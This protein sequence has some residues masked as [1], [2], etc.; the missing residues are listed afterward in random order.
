M[1]QEPVDACPWKI[2]PGEI[3]D[4]KKKYV[5]ECLKCQLVTHEEDLR[6]LVDY[7]SGSMHNWAGGYGGKLLAPE[8][9][10]VRRLTEI[11]T[12]Q[13]KH[14]IVKVLDF[15]SGSG[16]MLETL[17]RNFNAVGLEPDETARKKSLELGHTVY[18]EINEVVASGETFDLVTLFHVVEH[19]Y[20]PFEEFQ[21]IV[22]LLKPGGLV[23]VEPPNSQDALLTFYESA[24]FMNFTYWSHHPMLH[25]HNSI[26]EI[27]KRTGFEIIEN[28]GVQRYG[29]ANHLYWL[30]QF[31]PGGHVSW[32]SFFGPKTE[33]SYAADLASLGL[34]DTIW[35]LGMK[36]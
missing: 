21:G 33:S 5:Q 16:Q 17:S 27:V 1:Q 12:L 4:H 18:A 26:S 23:L 36:I 30:S 35:L 8:N 2:T 34:S 24:P 11:R 10:L 31:Q 9:D 7:S 22:Q 15:G 6:E 25:S 14:E 13:R 28:R 29:L 32:G 20:K 19:F 3:R